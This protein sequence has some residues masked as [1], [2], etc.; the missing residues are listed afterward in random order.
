MKRRLPRLLLQALN[1]PNQPIWFSLCSSSAD[2]L[3]RNH[4]AFTLLA[5]RERRDTSAPSVVK[6]SADGGCADAG[7]GGSRKLELAQHGAPL[8]DFPKTNVSKSLAGA[9]P[10]RS[11]PEPA[12]AMASFAPLSQCSCPAAN[13]SHRNHQPAPFASFPTAPKE[14]M[15]LQHS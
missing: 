11:A 13:L 15:S 4:D 14:N 12:H 8:N 5:Q 9:E 2:G 6:D 7:A 1:C 3:C 10:C